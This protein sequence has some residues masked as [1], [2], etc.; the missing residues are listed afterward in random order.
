MIVISDTSPVLNLSLIGRL[1][2]LVSLYKQVLI[3]P[4]VYRELTRSDV[5]PPLTD[6]ESRAWLVVEPAQDRSRV[7]QLRTELDAGEAEAIALAL[8]KQADLDP[9]GTCRVLD[10]P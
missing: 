10:R 2:V 7:A 9:D 4:A 3:P 5:G 1:D 8:E 6:R